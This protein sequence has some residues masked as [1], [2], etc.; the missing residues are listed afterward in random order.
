M[1]QFETFPNAPI[2]EALMDIIVQL[3]QETD[4]EQLERLYD[5]IKEKYPEKDKK[6]LF[7]ARVEFAKEKEPDIERSPAKFQGYI[8]KSSKEKKLIQA[9]INGFT[10]NKLKPYE[11]WD[12]FF[13]DGRKY[14]ELYKEIA[15]PLRVMRIALR[16]INRIEAK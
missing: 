1:N 14:W 7:E 16:Y 11:S 6:Y 8:F 2:T 3:P 12:K 9:K 10:F 5:H 4:P 13:C 15:K